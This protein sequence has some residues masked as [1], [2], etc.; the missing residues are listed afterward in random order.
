[1]PI[2]REHLALRASSSC[3]HTPWL[4]S[5]DGQRPE[6]RDQGL[7]AQPSKPESIGIDLAKRLAPREQRD[8][9]TS[10]HRRTRSL[11]RPGEEGCRGPCSGSAQGRCLSNWNSAALGGALVGVL[12]AVLPWWGLS[13]LLGFTQPVSLFRR[14]WSRGCGAGGG[15][16]WSSQ[17]APLE[18]FM[19]DPRSRRTPKRYCR[20]ASW[21]RLLPLHRR[22]CGS[23]GRPR[24]SLAELCGGVGGGRCW[25][26][27]RWVALR[28]RAAKT[29]GP[30]LPS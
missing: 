10:C 25:R 12:S 26:G 7:A 19:S 20:S 15:T 3:F 6:S 16:Y 1:V 9:E 14:P 24:L 2:W 18:V 22:L 21:D 27:A 5:L 23:G 11:R 8:L 13:R 4:A 30:G 29:V 28:Q 17:A